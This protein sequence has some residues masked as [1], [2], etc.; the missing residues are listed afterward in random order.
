MNDKRLLTDGVVAM[1]QLWSQRLTMIDNV[2]DGDASWD[3]MSVDEAY[4]A[5]L[6]DGKTELAND[7]LEAQ[8]MINYN[9]KQKKWNT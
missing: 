7:I 4:L 6:K 5:G 8:D 2:E 9:W 3:N 1:I